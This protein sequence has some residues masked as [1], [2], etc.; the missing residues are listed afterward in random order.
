MAAPLPPGAAGRM[1]AEP[2]LVRPAGR[3]DVD[4]MLSALADLAHLR[5]HPD[6]VPRYQTHR[7]SCG[8]YFDAVRAPSYIA[9]PALA[10]LGSGIGPVLANNY[11]QAWHFLLRPGVAQLGR[12]DIRGVR[13][14]RRGTAIA[15]P[16]YQV[17]AGDDVRWVVPPGAG[18]TKVLD[19][20]SALA[21][22]APEP[23][24]R[25]RACP[26]AQVR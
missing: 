10:L 12:W 17:T 6:W 24:R 26:T 1:P 18:V 25:A 20:E 15:V 2:Q 14:L 3:S 22:R 11:A 7:L 16:A 9:E 4:E 19:L 8:R 5:S 21:G 13:L 23:R